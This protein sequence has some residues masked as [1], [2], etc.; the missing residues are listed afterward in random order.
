MQRWI[1]AAI[2]SAALAAT[3]GLA[4]AGD[5]GHAYRGHDYGGQDYRGRDY[6]RGDRDYRGRNWRGHESWH[7]VPHRYPRHGYSGYGSQ[8][9]RAP[10]YHRWSRGVYL[11][12][13]Y[14]GPRYIVR[15]YGYYGLRPPPLGYGWVRVDNDFLLAALATGFVAE[16]LFGGY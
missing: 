2:A 1:K 7:P 13:A 10:G 5:R 15:D 4:Q 6:Y 8:G 14:F 12:R 9:W 16:V 3:T 11:P